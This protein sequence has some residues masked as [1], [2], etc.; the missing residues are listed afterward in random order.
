MLDG[1]ADID[2]RRLFCLTSKTNTRILD[3]SRA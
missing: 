1:R 2:S 3:A